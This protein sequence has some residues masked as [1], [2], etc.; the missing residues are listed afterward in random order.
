[1]PRWPVRSRPWGGHSCAPTSKC[2]GLHQGSFISIGSFIRSRLLRISKF[3]IIRCE[4]VL[5]RRV[6]MFS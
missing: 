6:A 5:S 4:K 2:D 1:V 3:L